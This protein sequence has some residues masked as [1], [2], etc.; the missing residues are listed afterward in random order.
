MHNFIKYWLIFDILSLQSHTA[1]A[2]RYICNALII[3]DPT[4]SQRVATLPCKH[5]YYIKL[6]LYWKADN[7]ISQKRRVHYLVGFS[8]ITLM[9]I[10]CWPHW[11]K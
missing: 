2:Y 11:W 10:Y 7:N 6:Y 8:V 5:Y 9:Q 3:S 1:V 4:R